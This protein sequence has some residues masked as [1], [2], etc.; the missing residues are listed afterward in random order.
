MT[1]IDEAMK[2]IHDNTYGG[3]EGLKLI[4]QQIEL[5]AKAARREALWGAMRF[6]QA[7]DYTCED[8]RALATPP[9]STYLTVDIRRGRDD[10]CDGIAEG[11]R[12]MAEEAQ[13]VD[14]GQGAEAERSKP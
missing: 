6:A 14:Q 10:A 1:A 2:V 8:R 4:R 12:R 9:G 11:L 13:V 5:V 7:W 3:A